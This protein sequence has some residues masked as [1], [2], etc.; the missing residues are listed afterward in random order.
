M[1]NF[2]KLLKT[3]LVA[4]FGA[5]FGQN[6]IFFKVLF[7]PPLLYAKF[8]TKNKKTTNQPIRSNT[9]FRRMHESKD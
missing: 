2:K 6:G 4:H 5:I 7:L 9:D 8:K 1:T 3:Q